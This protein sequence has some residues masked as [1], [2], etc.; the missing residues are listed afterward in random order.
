MTEPL[1][2]EPNPDNKSKTYWSK[3]N[4]NHSLIADNLMSPAPLQPPEVHFV[5]L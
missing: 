1:V 4:V 3:G 2:P 5:S